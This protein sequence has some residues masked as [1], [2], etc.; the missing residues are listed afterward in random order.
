MPAENLLIRIP[1]F[2]SLEY[3]A[4]QNLHVFLKL[5]LNTLLGNKDTQKNLCRLGSLWFNPEHSMCFV[6]KGG[7]EIGSG[8]LDSNER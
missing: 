2:K 8:S 7:A 6:V 1:D 5:V 3:S 4:L